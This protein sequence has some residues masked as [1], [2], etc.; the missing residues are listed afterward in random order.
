M[1]IQ[2]GSN[3]KKLKEDSFRQTDLQLSKKPVKYYIWST[4]VNGTDTWTLRKAPG[5]T[6][7]EVLKTIS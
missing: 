5:G 7:L 3:V 4:A 2:I 6:L 1:C